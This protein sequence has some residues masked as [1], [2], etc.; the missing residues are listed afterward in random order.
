[1]DAG[2]HRA[3]QRQGRSLLPIGIVSVEGSF[4]KG[5]VV[6][7]CCPDGREFARGLTNYPA[8][9]VRRIAGRKSHLIA[10]ILGHHP[11]DEVLHRDNISVTKGVGSRE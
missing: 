8:K 3:V 2:A 5:D 10:E 11:Y 4:N 7:L 6:S 1:L 9:E